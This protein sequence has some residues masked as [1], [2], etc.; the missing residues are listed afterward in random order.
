[1][2]DLVVEEDAIIVQL[3]WIFYPWL[4]FWPIVWPVHPLTDCSSQGLHH[5]F[6]SGKTKPERIYNPI[7]AM[8]FLAMF[9]FQRDNTKR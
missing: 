4:D 5:E 3:S 1:M 9:T 8:K 2:G 7:T 6:Y